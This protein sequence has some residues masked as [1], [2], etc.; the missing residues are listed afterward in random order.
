MNIIYLLDLN[1]TLVSN[2]NEKRSPFIEQIKREQYRQWLIDILRGRH[3]ILIT[4]RPEKYREPTLE[5]IQAKTGAKFPEAYFNGSNLPPHLY[6]R[7]TFRKV[8]QPLYSGS[9]FVAIESN[10]RTIEEYK[11]CGVF[12]LSVQ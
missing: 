7:D 8:I 11:K 12:C 1:Y 6:K 10:P 9:A 3:V 5:S 4:A 2:S